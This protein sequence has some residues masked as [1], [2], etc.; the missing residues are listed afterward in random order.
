LL[1]DGGRAESFPLRDRFSSAHFDLLMNDLHQLAVVH[2]RVAFPSP[3]QQA[4]YDASDALFL[5]RCSRKAAD[6]REAEK[7]LKLATELINALADSRA[8][9][10]CGQPFMPAR[11]DAWYCS[12]KCR[13]RGYR[14]RRDAKSVTGNT[15]FAGPSAAAHRT[16]GT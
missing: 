16:R 4:I 8:C 14:Q 13:Q 2:L 6:L 5:F 12:D 15:Q 10:G 7:R 11:Q 3:L 9:K 1:I